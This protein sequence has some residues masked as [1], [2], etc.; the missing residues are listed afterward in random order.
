MTQQ[1]FPSLPD[2]YQ[3]VLYL[4]QQQNS[5]EVIPLEE[6][7][8]GRTGAKLFLVSISRNDASFV[9]HLILKLDHIHKKIKINEYVKEINRYNDCLAE[10]KELG[11][12]AFFAEVLR[13]YPEFDAIF[14]KRLEQKPHRNHPI[15]W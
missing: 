15:R 3:Q 9:D 11:E 14:K 1:Y 2:E 10:N 4:A 5:I 12:K 13:K 8:G 7:K 6:I